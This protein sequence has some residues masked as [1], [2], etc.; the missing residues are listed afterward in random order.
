MIVWIDLETSGLDVGQDEILEVACIITEDDLTEVNRYEWLVAPVHGVMD[1]YARAMHVK[2]GLLHDLNT[3]P[4][5]RREDVEDAL[6]EFIDGAAGSP[7]AGSSVGF[8]RAFIQRYMPRVNNVLHYRNI[9]VS[10]IKELVKRWHPS[11][12]I[13]VPEEDKAHRA[14]ADLEASIAELKYYQETVFVP[15]VKGVNA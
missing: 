6:V 9:D 14:M 13:T 8:D 2:S 1:E 12:A 3:L 15:S 7:L 11:L 10:T 4:V 5:L